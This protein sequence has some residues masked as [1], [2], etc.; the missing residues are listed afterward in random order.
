[1]LVWYIAMLD[2]YH[3]YLFLN[4]KLWIYFY[5][6]IEKLGHFLL[7]LLLKKNSEM[8]VMYHFFIKKITNQYQDQ[9]GYAS[10]E[11]GFRV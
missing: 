1:M 11:K 2:D 7:N 3:F 5:K 8:R 4:D 6:G 10:F 9:T